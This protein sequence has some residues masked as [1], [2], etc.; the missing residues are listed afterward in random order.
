MGDDNATS[1]RPMANV[2]TEAREGR[3]GIAMTAEDFVY[4][5]RDCQ[6]FKDTILA[7]QRTADAIHRQD[8]WG[9][10]E[11]EGKMVS[12]QTLV[13]RFRSKANNAGDGNSVW[14][15]MEQHYKIVEDIQE[16]HRV[17]RERMMQSDSNF[18]A[19]FNHL[20][21]TLPERPPVPLKVGPYVLPDG[22][23]R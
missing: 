4:I 5:D 8:N 16:V 19:E 23:A 15:I 7:V 22:S 13:G 17:V 18:A 6:Y 20:N 21:E 14:Q 10:G 9:L 11:K 2:L 1:P 3:L 12:A